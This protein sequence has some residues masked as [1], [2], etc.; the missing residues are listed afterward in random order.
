MRHCNMSVV[1]AIDGEAGHQRMVDLPLVIAVVGRPP[2]RSGLSITCVPA[3]DATMRRVGGR[4]TR[5]RAG[6]AGSGDHGPVDARVFRPE[7]AWGCFLGKLDELP[8][9]S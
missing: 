2:C 8:K 5:R 4:S 6:V 9:D 7:S 1:I 3:P